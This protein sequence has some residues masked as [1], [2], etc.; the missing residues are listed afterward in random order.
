M[1]GRLLCLFG[2][3]RWAG[4]YLFRYDG[5]GDGRDEVWWVEVCVRCEAMRRLFKG[6]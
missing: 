3:H 6:E 4:M 1:L 2:L 5:E